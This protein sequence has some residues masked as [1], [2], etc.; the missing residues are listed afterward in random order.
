MCAHLK[1]NDAGIV[2]YEYVPKLSQNKSIIPGT[3]IVV[4]CLNKNEFLKGSRTLTCEYDGSWT[5]LDKRFNCG[6]NTTFFTSRLET[7]FY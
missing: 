1:P 2:T 3:K 6:Q 5:G 4:K 7:F